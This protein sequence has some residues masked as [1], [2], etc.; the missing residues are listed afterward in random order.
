MIRR[1]LSGRSGMSVVFAMFVFMFCTIVSAFVV[2]AAESNILR[3][4][5]MKS[6]EQARLA[7][8][9]AVSVLRR[10]LGNMYV[11]YT[12]SYSGGKWTRSTL[13]ETPYNTATGRPAYYTVTPLDESAKQNTALDITTPGLSVDSKTCAAM[14]A[15]IRS[16][17]NTGLPA[18]SPDEGNPEAWAIHAGSGSDADKAL[19]LSVYACVGAGDTGSAFSFGAPYSADVTI[20][21]YDLS[22]RFTRMPD[23]AEFGTL[24]APYTLELSAPADCAVTP[25]E[26]VTEWE[27]IT[28][29]AELLTGHW[30]VKTKAT[31]LDV[32]VQ[33]P[34]DK[35]S[36]KKVD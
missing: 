34:A 6:E 19:S 12:L 17:V 24:R 27:W 28:D 31:V 14:E 16:A 3:T 29:V 25:R 7:A 32:A 2:N 13:T 23:P 5:V 15:L 36:V 1:K 9:S 18:R 33:W 35:M 11:S 10:Q 20:Q 4:G 26:V 30:A 21:N 8:A 22:L